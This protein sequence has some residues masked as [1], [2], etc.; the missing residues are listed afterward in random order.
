MVIPF[1]AGE[2]V[3]ALFN[4]ELNGRPLVFPFIKPEQS[5]SLPSD[6]L[7]TSL[8]DWGIIP[9]IIQWVYMGLF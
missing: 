1:S 7:T 3:K 6:P 4:G 5:F 8:P 9:I 2:K